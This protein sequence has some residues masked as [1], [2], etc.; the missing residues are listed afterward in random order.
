M[1]T[2]RALRNAAAGSA[3]GMALA[4]LLVSCGPLHS[5]AES[6]SPGGNPGGQA[7]G[8]V[9]APSTAHTS[10]RPTSPGIGHAPT[11]APSPPAGPLAA[12]HRLTAAGGQV[13][14]GDGRLQPG[15]AGP[16]VL[17]LQ[18]RLVSL[19]YW[20][21][22]PDG[23]YGSLTV[24]AVYALQK[25]AGLSRDGLMG[26]P[27]QQA[28]RAGIRPRARFQAGRHLEVDVARQLLLIVDGGQ[29]SM[30]LNTSTGS[31]VPYL[32]SGQ[33]YS[34]HTPTGTW[35]VTRQVDALDPGPLGDLWRPKYITNDGIAVHGAPEVPAYPASHGCIRV[36]DA[37]MDWIWS[38]GL[39]PIGTTVVVF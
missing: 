14:A 29:V 23:A 31:N 9:P 28:L 32:L 35:Q 37:A 17:A 16:R 4:T 6:A 13:Q 12:A 19:G 33:R 24:Q 21:G 30:V 22:I 38:T 2:R 18:E 25:A 5:A 20:L 15:A 27:T 36:S 11:T 8:P 26:A 1:H 39:A 10:P 3:A 7:A 34:A